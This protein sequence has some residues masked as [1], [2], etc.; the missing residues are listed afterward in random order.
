MGSAGHFTT[1]I[2]DSSRSRSRSTFQS[3]PRSQSWRTGDRVSLFVSVAVLVLVSVGTVLGVVSTALAA[4]LKGLVRTWAAIFPLAITRPQ[5][6]PHRVGHCAHD[7]GGGRRA[8][9]PHQADH[10]RCRGQRPLPCVPGAAP[11]LGF[12]LALQVVPL[13]WLCTT[14]GIREWYSPETT[15]WL[16]NCQLLAGGAC[17]NLRDFLRFPTCRKGARCHRA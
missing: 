13:I 9:S 7:H 8:G 11:L 15:I 4:C 17:Q 16:L 10:R 5:T 1:R 3:W 12:G 2:E 6:D 14:G